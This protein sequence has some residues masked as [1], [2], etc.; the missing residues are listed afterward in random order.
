MNRDNGYLYSNSFAKG[1]K[2]NL[3]CFKKG[4]IPWNKGVKGIH[5][6]TR[7]EFKK[8]RQPVNKKSVGAITLRTHRGEVRQWIKVAEPDKWQLYSVFLWESYNH[9]K[10]PKNYVIHHINKDKLD[11][12]IENL[13]LLNRSEHINIHRQDLR[14]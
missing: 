10:V 9:T 12:R 8:G 5:N 3:G 7:T 4:H 13:K 1:N 6:S 2:S 14:N 11:D